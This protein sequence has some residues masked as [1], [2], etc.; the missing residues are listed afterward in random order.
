M[1][2]NKNRRFECF[3]NNNF[4]SSHTRHEIGQISNR[5][6]CCYDIVPRGEFA[7]EA[8]RDHPLRVT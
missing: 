5:R 3:S 6:R 2:K 1:I 8:E 7:S 4:Y